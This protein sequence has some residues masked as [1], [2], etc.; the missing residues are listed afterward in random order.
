MGRIKTQQAKR[1]GQE[2]Y[3][4]HKEHFKA[5]FELNKL[6]FAKLIDL[7]SKKLRNVVVGYITR[8]A[9]RDAESN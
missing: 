7:P 8:L 6:V 2:T 4:A 3:D 9:K 5:D 1:I